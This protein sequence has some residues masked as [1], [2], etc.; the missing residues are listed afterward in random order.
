MAYFLGFRLRELGGNGW[1]LP[2]SRAAALP[3]RS[4]RDLR[5]AAEGYGELAGGGE[6]KG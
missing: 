4:A 1:D 6:G 5:F 3:I 2:L